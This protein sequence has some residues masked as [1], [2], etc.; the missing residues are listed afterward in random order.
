MAINFSNINLEVIDT[1]TNATPDI[2]INQNG[3]TF[4]KRVLE[5]LGY[6]Q[7]VQYCMDAA[8]R[9]FAIR[10]CKSNEAKATAFSNRPRRSVAVTIISTTPLPSSLRITITK[11]A[12]R[13]LVS[14]MPSS[15][16]CILI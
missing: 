2:Y 11:N 16:L 9:V 3:I 5:D 15:V 12:T 7:N 13:S 10:P 8:Q 1:T 14:T 4:S 6:P